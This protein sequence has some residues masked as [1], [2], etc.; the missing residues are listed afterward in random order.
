V[1]AEARDA[2]LDA[3]HF[4]CR[5]A[6]STATGRFRGGDEFVCYGGQSDGRDE[7]VVACR[8]ETRQKHQI[9]FAWRRVGDLHGVKWSVRNFSEEAK[10]PHD[11]LSL[12][13]LHAEQS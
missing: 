7:K 4:E 11:S 1:R 12:R 2:R 3:R 13:P 9:D 8:A 10:C 6:T 5:P